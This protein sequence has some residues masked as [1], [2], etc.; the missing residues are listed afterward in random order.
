[1]SFTVLDGAYHTY[2]LFDSGQRTLLCRYSTTTA[3]QRPA[4]LDDMAFRPQ[5]A[6]IVVEAR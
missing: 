4:A 6:G 3:P 5:L 1:M 2:G